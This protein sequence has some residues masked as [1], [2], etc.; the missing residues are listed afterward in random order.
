MTKEQILQDID[1][2]EEI[3]LNDSVKEKKVESEEEA[4]RI[5]GKAIKP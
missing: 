3:L 5:I 4:N 2:V 1:L